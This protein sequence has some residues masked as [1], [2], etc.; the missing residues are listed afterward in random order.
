MVGVAVS[1]D[2]YAEAFRAAFEQESE[3]RKEDAAIETYTESLKKRAEL[4]EE[5]SKAEENVRLEQERIN[6]LSVAEKLFVGAVAGSG[7]I[8]EDLELYKDALEELNNAQNENEDIISRIEE[9]WEATASAAEEAGEAQMT[10]G[11]AATEAIS[12]VSE[13][14][15]ELCSEYDKAYESALNSIQGQ[16]SLWD[17]IGEIAAMSSN[18]I[19]EAL[20]SQIDFWESYSSNLDGLMDKAASIE[21]LESVLNSV[22]DGSEDSAAMLAGMAS[23]SEIGRAHV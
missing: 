10:A 12:G 15:E 7:A 2:N 4:T 22:A 21:G 8:D 23:M 17:S 5:I 18:D 9:N 1:A 13:H 3:Q 20:Q 6:N 19:T 14:L 11:E 16:Y